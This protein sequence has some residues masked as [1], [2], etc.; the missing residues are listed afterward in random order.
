MIRMASPFP[1]SRLEIMP[2]CFGSTNVNDQDLR[3]LNG[4]TG[5]RFC[6]CSLE[7]LYQPIQ[8]VE[9]RLYRD[10]QL[11]YL[12]EFLDD[13][14]ANAIGLQL[15]SPFYV[16][17]DCL[18]V[19]TAKA[20]GIPVAPAAQYEIRFH[21]ALQDQKKWFP[22]SLHQLFGLE[23]SQWQPTE[24]FSNGLNPSIRARGCHPLASIGTGQRGAPALYRV[25]VEYK[26]DDI[27]ELQ[28]IHKWQLI[29]WDLRIRC[30]WMDRVPSDTPSPEHMSGISNLLPPKLSPT[31][32][33]SGASLASLAVPTIKIPEPSLRRRLKARYTPRD[34]TSAT[35]TKR[36]SSRLESKEVVKKAKQSGN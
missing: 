20:G 14:I 25:R 8:G 7:I 32:I 3:F 29:V 12:T 11:C 13:G 22:L 33:P 19:L 1:G 9:R 26:H 4:C 23:P 21:F 10:E 34:R 16:D 35:M 36:R 31:F 24:N 5:L 17:A 28:P 6:Q 30:R 15:K 2:V 18:V 27:Q